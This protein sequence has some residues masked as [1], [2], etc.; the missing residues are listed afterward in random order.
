MRIAIHFVRMATAIAFAGTFAQ[1][2]RSSAQENTRTR[3]VVYGRKAGMALTMDVWK[4]AK[5]NGAGAI[6]MISGAFISGSE[7]V[8]SGFFRARHL[9]AISGSHTCPS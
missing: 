1:A 6:F 3:D 8:D 5:Q 7:K 2:S 4:P 9:Q